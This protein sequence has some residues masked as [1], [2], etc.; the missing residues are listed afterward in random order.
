MKLKIF[1]CFMTLLFA[2]AT[3]K[4]N[5]QIHT[6]IFINGIPSSIINTNTLKIPEKTIPIPDGF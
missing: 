6:K 5:A 4:T 1:S 2:I 3:I